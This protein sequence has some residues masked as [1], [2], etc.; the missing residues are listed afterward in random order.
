MNEWVASPHEK[1]IG[2]I[3]A[4]H[5][6]SSVHFSISA[7]AESKFSSENHLDI[8]TENVIFNRC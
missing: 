5:M 7:N 6:Q 4:I 3:R 2:A 1:N 8:F